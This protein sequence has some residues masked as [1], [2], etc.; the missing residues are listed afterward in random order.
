MSSESLSTLIGT[1]TIG[2][3]PFTDGHCSM[4]AR[5]SPTFSRHFSHGN[6]VRGALS[7]RLGKT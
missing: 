5:A 4:M 3:M 1:S 7:G 6:F 2:E